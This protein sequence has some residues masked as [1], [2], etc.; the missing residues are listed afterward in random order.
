MEEVFNLR[1]TFLA[2]FY[3]SLHGSLFLPAIF[4]FRM[5]GVII[6]FSAALVIDLVATVMI[7]RP[8]SYAF[9]SGLVLRNMPVLIILTTIIFGAPVISAWLSIY[10]F[11]KTDV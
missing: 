1:V 2:I 6:L 11:N 9:A 5:V 10:L 8:D 7:F 4:R 3:L